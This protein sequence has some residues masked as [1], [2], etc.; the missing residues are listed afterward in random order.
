MPKLQNVQQ[1]IKINSTNVILEDIFMT[2]AFE[3]MTTNS[4]SGLVRLQ[5]ICVQFG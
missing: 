1:H 3:P 4:K 5:E 2:F